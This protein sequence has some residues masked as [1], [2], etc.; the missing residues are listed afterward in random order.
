MSAGFDVAGREA[1]ATTPPPRDDDA[2]SPTVRDKVVS[3]TKFGFDIDPET[4]PRIR[5]GQSTTGFDSRPEHIREVCDASLKRLR[6]DRID[7][8]YQHRVD[9]D[10]PIEDVAGT[11][12][13]LVKAGKVKC[14]GMSEA[15]AATIRRAHAVQPVAAVQNEYSLWTRLP[16]LG[17]IRT[18]RELGVAFVPF[19]PVGRG[20][21]A[22]EI[23]DPATFAAAD[24]RKHNPRFLEPDFSHN[25]AIIEAFRAD[26]EA[27]GLSP[28]SLALAWILHRGDHLVPIPGTRSI[29]HLEENAAATAI[30]LDEADMARI[31]TLLPCGFAHGDRYS[32]AQYHGPERYC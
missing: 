32:E 5:P 12:G 28:A 8:F 13:E 2:R 1:P 30:D 9:P 20:M 14:F 27:R 19:S 11:V 18:C 15:D 25:V 31:E 4:G 26:A 3:A 24:F 23:P 16:E 6:T 29:A 22:R 7:L 17:L 10:V 21:F